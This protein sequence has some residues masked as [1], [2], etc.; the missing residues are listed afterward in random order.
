MGTILS[1]PYELNFA[2]TAR[3]AETIE[4][5]V[6]T[7]TSGNTK[8]DVIDNLSLACNSVHD[9]TIYVMKITTI[10]TQAIK[11][12]VSST[13]DGRNPI[14]SNTA[15]KI[16]EYSTTSEANS[17]GLDSRVRRICVPIFSMEP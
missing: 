2:Q 16:G 14:D 10:D 12:R 7:F 1:N 11:Y 4:K 6:E 15:R 8:Y 13:T 3:N 5:R 9:E 17:G